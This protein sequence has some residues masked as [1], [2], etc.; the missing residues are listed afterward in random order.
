MVTQSCN[1]TE[2]SAKAIYHL[3]AQK[4]NLDVFSIIFLICQ[5]L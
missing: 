1:R 4:T 2:R 3:D 5:N